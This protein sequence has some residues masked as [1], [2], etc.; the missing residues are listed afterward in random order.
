[1]ALIAK[2][3][4]ERKVYDIILRSTDNTWTSPINSP[5]YASYP[6]NLN[7]IMSQ[8][9]LARPYYLSFT[10][11]SM[12]IEET[13]TIT[14][15]APIEVF[16][17]FRSAGRYQHMVST[18]STFP[19]GLLNFQSNY[20]PNNLHFGLIADTVMNNP[21]YINTLSGCDSV[22]LSFRNITDNQI[23]LNSRFVIRIHLVPADY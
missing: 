16:L 7:Q 4:P 14:N 19:V 23:V 11:M 3:R 18:D 17:N 1:M 13:P 6:L 20:D 5:W 8:E 15:V 9:E 10:F 22:F 12:I 21:V 2:T